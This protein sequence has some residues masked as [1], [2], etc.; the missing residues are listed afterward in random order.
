MKFGVSVS[1]HV[2]YFDVFTDIILYVVEPNKRSLASAICIAINHLFGDA[3][4]PYII[5]LVTKN[6]ISI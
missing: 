2:F 3:I 1:N 6:Y 5:G 4:S